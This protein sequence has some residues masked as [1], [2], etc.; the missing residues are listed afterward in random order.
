MRS[1]FPPTT[2]QP[3]RPKHGKLREREPRVV[4][5][6]RFFSAMG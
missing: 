2:I 4:R 3:S 6:Q 5:R 1:P